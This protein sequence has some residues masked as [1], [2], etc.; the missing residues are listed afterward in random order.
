MPKQL[1][2]TAVFATS[3]VFAPWQAW[4]EDASDAPI[5]V[6]TMLVPEPTGTIERQFFGRIT[7]K[8][9]V[10]LAFE[11]GGQIETL[12]ASEGAFVPEGTLIGV[13]D[14][15]PFERRVERAELT[16]EQTFRALRRSQS[17]ALKSVASQVR[18]EDAQTAFDLADVELRDARAALEDAYIFAPFDAQVSARIASPHTVTEPGQPIVRLHDL[19]ELRVQ[20]ELPERLLREVGDVKDVTFLGAVP[21]KQDRIP[22]QFRE[23]RAETGDVGQSYTVSLAID[24]GAAK[25]LRPGQTM[26][27]TG[28]IAADTRDHII[29]STAIATAP[30]GTQYVVM[31]EP[32]DTGLQAVH[33]PISIAA[34]TGS[35]LS[36]R[37]LEPG[38]EIVEVGAHAVANGALV[39]RYLG[40]SRTGG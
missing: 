14:L 38:L 34:P 17:L 5:P 20:F 10:A 12:Q 6:R 13:L 21:G 18:A 11:V 2:R 40:L 15:G 27:V 22:L 35:N 31:I 1:L 36:V 30:D 24:P 39:K 25:S 33:A 4:A 26:Q 7:A 8:D 19:S 9:T 16:Y 23:F 37:G 28:R 32:S 29:P 3:L